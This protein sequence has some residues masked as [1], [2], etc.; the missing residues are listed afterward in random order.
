M[1]DFAVTCRVEGSVAVLDLRGLL[2]R[3]A[4]EQFAAAFTDALAAADG[5]VVLNFRDV[6]FINSTGIA[7][8]VGALARGRT[9]GREVRAFGLDE[10]YRHIFE[11][12]RLADFIGIFDDE[13]TALAVEGVAHA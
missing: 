13:P 1:N 5:P 6:G 7:L 10:H 12:T 9:L 3:A 11:I 4:E 8:V 2:D